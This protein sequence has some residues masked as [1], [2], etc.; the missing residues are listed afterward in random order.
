MQPAM[1]MNKPL[2]P[3]PPSTLRRPGGFGGFAFV[4][5]GVIIASVTIGNGELVQASRGGAVFGYS[6]LWCFLFA[7]LFKAVQVYA[8]ARYMTLTGQ[9]PITTWRNMPGPTLWFPLLLILPTLAVM[10]VGFS[11]IAEIVGSYIRDLGGFSIEAPTVWGFERPEFWQNV[12]ATAILSFCLLLALASNLTLLQRISTAVVGILLIC[13]VLSVLVSGPDLFKILLGLFMPRIDAYQPWVLNNYGDEFIGRNQWL[14]VAIYLS[15]VGGGTY[16][17]V[18]YVALLREKKWG[19][20]G[21][22]VAGR[23]QLDQAV[24]NPRTGKEMI[25]RARIWTRAPLWD[26][27]VSF[28]AVIL[29]TLLFAVLG[30]TMLHEK[31]V[32]PATGNM[33]VEQEQFLVNLHYQLRWVYRAGVFMAYVGTLYGAFEIYQYTFV[34]SLRALLPG[35]I[36]ARTIPWWRRLMVGFCYLGAMIFIWLREAV[37]G[38]VLGRLTFGA[39]LGGATL[40]GL[41]CF[42]MLWT[43]RTHLPAPLRMSRPLWI[44][45]LV[46]GLCMTA[47]GV[48]TL[49]VYFS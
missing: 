12:W 15:A 45:V 37:S 7:G 10:P 14:E 40:C 35:W 47:L 4:G 43:D 5:P 24:S 39:V 29:V 13:A 36:C 16:D 48:Q 23:S 26:T 17:Y 22:P 41:W 25:R 27:C 38:D 46:A 49:V 3:N 6:I 11:A 1:N 34:E 21:G 33:L 28:T 9:H 8:A 42:A 30:A 32:I 20:A 2:Y 31:Q 19:L 44:A 18:G